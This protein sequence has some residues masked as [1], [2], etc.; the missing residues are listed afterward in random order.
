MTSASS[1]CDQTFATIQQYISTL[2]NDPTQGAQVPVTT[3]EFTYQL[4]TKINS[5]GGISAYCN[6]IATT[7]NLQLVEQKVFNSVE[8]SRIDYYFV[9]KPIGVVPLPGIVYQ[10]LLSTVEWNAELEAPVLGTKL[11][12]SS[13]SVVLTFYADAESWSLSDIVLSI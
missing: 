1:A 9:H 3:K 7:L 13:L 12:S 11:P 4:I 5:L 8:Q 10:N 2:L 6:N